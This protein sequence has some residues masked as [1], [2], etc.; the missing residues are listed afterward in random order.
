[1]RHR[2]LERLTEFKVPGLL[3]IIPE[4]GSFNIK[5]STFKLQLGNKSQTNL[6]S[7]YRTETP[8][9]IFMGLSSNKICFPE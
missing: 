9:F 6:K 7:E 5:L 2:G 4:E 8:S 3:W 1:M